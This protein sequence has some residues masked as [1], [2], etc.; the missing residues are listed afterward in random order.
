MNLGVLVRESVGFGLE[1]ESEIL[2]VWET[3][4]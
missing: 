1:R 4:E 2:R 3:S